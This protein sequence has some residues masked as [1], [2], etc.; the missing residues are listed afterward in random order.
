MRRVGGSSSEEESG[1]LVCSG[2]ARH[3]PTSVGCR[4]VLLAF[5]SSP[6]RSGNPAG[7]ETKTGPVC[8]FAEGEKED[9][10]FAL[11]KKN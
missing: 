5:P 4:M 8:L 1:V 10:G 9:V 6:G 3:I 11:R 2:W 7:T